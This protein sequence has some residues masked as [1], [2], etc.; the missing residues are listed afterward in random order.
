MY[1]I[2]SYYVTNTL[3][4]PD[5]TVIEPNPKSVSYQPG[6]TLIASG[7]YEKSDVMYDTKDFIPSVVHNL[8]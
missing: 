1:A 2:R 5:I 4:N 7:V 3:S 6:N 8:V